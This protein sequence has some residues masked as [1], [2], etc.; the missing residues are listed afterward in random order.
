MVSGTGTFSNAFSP[1]ATVSGLSAG[2]NILRWTISTACTSSISQV[3]ITSIGTLTA[4]AGADQTVCSTVANLNALVPGNGNGSWSLVSGTAQISQTN[5]PVSAVT[6]LSEGANTF[7]WTVTSGA[8]NASD[9]VTIT[10]EPDLLDLGSDTLLCEGEAISLSAGGT[11]AAYFWSD[12]SN[13][14]NILVNSSGQYWLQV[15]SL[16][17]CIFVDTIQVVLIPCTGIEDVLAEE[18]GLLKVFPNPSEGKFSILNTQQKAA[19][20]EYRVISGSGRQVYFRAAGAL[21][22]G[23]YF[24]IDLQGMPPGLYLLEARSPSGRMLEKLML[25]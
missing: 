21:G 23:N 14:Q 18:D 12:N 8:C 5:N 19:Q 17:G 16:N 6:S 1:T 9:L 15:V 22:A 7:L 10:R 2:S 25:R 3:T 13:N 11:Y 20:T 24:E 4:N